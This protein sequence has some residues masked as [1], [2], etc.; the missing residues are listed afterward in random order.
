MSSG[1]SDTPFAS[2]DPPKIA[3]GP[4]D[5]AIA[6]QHID[7]QKKLCDSLGQGRRIVSPGEA[8]EQFADMAISS[9]GREASRRLIFGRVPLMTWLAILGSSR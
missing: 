1:T 3:V 2:H 6:G 5:I 8:I 4:R 7:P 9:I